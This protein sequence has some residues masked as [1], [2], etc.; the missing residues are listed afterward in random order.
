MSALNVHYAHPVSVGITF[1]KMLECPVENKDEKLI[2]MFKNTIAAFLFV[3]II[4]SQLISR[5]HPNISD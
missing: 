2:H 5:S 3:L 1:V 4:Y